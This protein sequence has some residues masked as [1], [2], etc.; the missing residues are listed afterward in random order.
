MN[1]GCL[2]MP[3][4][5]LISILPAC[6]VAFWLVSVTHPFGEGWCVIIEIPMNQ[7]AAPGDAKNSVGNP[8]PKVKAQRR[9][10]QFDDTLLKAFTLSQS[11]AADCDGARIVEG[12]ETTMKRAL[13][14]GALGSARLAQ[15]A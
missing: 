15:E 14:F 7:R 2:V 12:D 4:R 11:A 1:P 8:H 5:A 6:S 9:T 13:S 3:M 10:P